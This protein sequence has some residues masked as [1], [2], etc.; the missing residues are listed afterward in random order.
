MQSP[1]Q[2]LLSKHVAGQTSKNNRTF[3]S[4]PLVHSGIFPTFVD[5]RAL[6]S[7]SF[8]QRRVK[9]RHLWTHSETRL[10]L[11][12]LNTLFIRE[13]S[14]FWTEGHLL[15]EKWSISPRRRRDAVLKKH[16]GFTWSSSRIH[17]L[18]WRRFSS[19]ITWSHTRPERNNT[20][21]AFTKYKYYTTIITH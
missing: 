15:Y 11:Q 9:V 19:V 10:Q 17:L 4:L 13:I 20:L 5:N 1:L 7:A 2:S 6:D 8:Q 3:L 14:C 21:H 16:A 18:T 12:T